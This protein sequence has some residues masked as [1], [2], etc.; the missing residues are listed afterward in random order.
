LRLGRRGFLAAGGA[1]AAGSFLH[2]ALANAASRPISELGVAPDTG[3]DLSEALQKAIAELSGAGQAVL[4]PGGTYNLSA[5]VLPERCAI[6][7]VPGQTR[8]VLQGGDSV[9]TAQNAEAV[10]LSGLIVEGGALA[11]SAREATIENVRVSRA[12]G[13][14]LTLTGAENVNVSRCR[15]E[16]C[17]TAAIDIMAGSAN[18]IGNLIAGCKTGIALAGSG[19][20][21]GNTIRGATDFGLRLGGGN[22][23]GTIFAN[24]NIISDCG[25]GIGVATGEETLLVSLN[26]ITGLQG[27][28]TAAIRA[29]H[30]NDLVGP[31]LAF[32]SAEAYLNLTVVGNVAR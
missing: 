16:A 32:E 1:V 4:L 17:G 8:L 28:T 22:E 14:G 29:F 6:F 26:M 15:F 31:D 13:A 2:A 12:S 3:D 30:G 21:T 18:L 5:V 19:H 11:G 20:A 23:G 9:F 25:I 27:K 24:G 10:S 7:G